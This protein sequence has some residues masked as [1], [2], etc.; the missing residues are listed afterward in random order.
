MVTDDDALITLD[1]A[2]DLVPGFDAEALKR[3]FRRSKLT[4]YKPGKKLLTTKRH[5]IEAVKINCRAVPAGAPAIASRPDAASMEI[6][7]AELALA[8]AELREKGDAKR[9]AARAK[10][11]PPRTPNQ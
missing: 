5:V 2:A 7:N 11:R 1:E 3:L 6:S 4:C 10:A 8:R 9:K